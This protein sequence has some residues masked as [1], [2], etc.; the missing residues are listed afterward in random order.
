M[1]SF[2]RR[3][4][5]KFVEYAVRDALISLTHALWMEDFNFNLGGLGIPLTLS[6]IGR[7]YVKK[8]VEGNK[9]PW[10]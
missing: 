3:D 10:I 9:V 2:L 8:C 5:V 6:S 4:M 7:R 1:Q